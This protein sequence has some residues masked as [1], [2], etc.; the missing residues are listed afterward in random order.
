MFALCL[1]VDDYCNRY[2]AYRVRSLNASDHE[3]MTT[4]SRATYFVDPREV[5]VMKREKRPSITML[6]TP[7][8]R[9]STALLSKILNVAFR[10]ANIA[11]M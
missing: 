9:S 7:D 5:S 6:G 1:H 11:E 4:A 10:N 3:L 8:N 2:D